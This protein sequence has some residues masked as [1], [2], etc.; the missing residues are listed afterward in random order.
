MSQSPNIIVDLPIRPFFFFQFL[1]HVFLN[2]AFRCIH[3][4]DC[5][6]LLMNPY[7][8]RTHPNLSSN[9]IFRVFPRTTFVTTFFINQD[10][11]IA[12]VI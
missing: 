8:S 2:S 3:T 6:V 4:K 12:Q 7:I 10:T 5:Y 11:E 1:F 9:P